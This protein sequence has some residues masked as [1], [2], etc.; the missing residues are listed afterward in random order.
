[1]RN[2]MGHYHDPPLAMRGTLNLHSYLR[3]RTS[4]VESS[5]NP[6]H[7]PELIGSSD[8]RI[9]FLANEMLLIYGNSVTD[10]AS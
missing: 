7:R 2:N 4:G 9:T 5:L 1:M 8:Q 10:P 3:K 6:E